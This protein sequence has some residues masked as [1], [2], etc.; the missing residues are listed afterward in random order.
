M[1]ESNRSGAVAHEMWRDQFQNGALFVA[2]SGLSAAAQRAIYLRFWEN[3]EIEEIAN[4]LRISWDQADRL[5]EN[6][7]KILRL[8]LSKNSGAIAA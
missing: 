4:E 1:K 5:I 3:Y 7:L 2:V 6:A 8:Q